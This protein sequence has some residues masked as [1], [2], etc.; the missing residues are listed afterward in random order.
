M[1]LN[2]SRCYSPSDQYASLATPLYITDEKNYILLFDGEHL[3]FMGILV[4]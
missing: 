3:S 4:I 1:A 2:I